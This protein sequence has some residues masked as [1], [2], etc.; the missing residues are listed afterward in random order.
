MVVWNSGAERMFGYT[1]GEMIG[2]SVSRIAP[3]D[4]QQS[5]EDHLQL[6]LEKDG[7]H[8]YEVKRVAL[9]PGAARAVPVVVAA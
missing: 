4:L 7:M 3:D 1:A 2:S 6:M 8:T 9:M 5:L